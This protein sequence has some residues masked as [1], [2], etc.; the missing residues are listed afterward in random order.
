MGSDGT[1]R[2]KFHTGCRPNVRGM[3]FKL[4]VVII[5]AWSLSSEKTC[6]KNGRVL[7]INT[8][9]VKLR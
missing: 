3:D 1:V 2:L 5:E 4:V 7:T 6:Q 8:F 9:T